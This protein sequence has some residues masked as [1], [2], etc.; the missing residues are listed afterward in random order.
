MCVAPTGQ[1][2]VQKRVGGRVENCTG[3]NENH[4]SVSCRQYDRE[5]GSGHT[6]NSTKSE[7]GSCN[8][9]TCVADGHPCIGQAIAHCGGSHRHAVRIGSAK[10][11]KRICIH[12][13]NGVGIEDADSRGIDSA[14]SEEFGR[15]DRGT[16]EDEVDAGLVNKSQDGIRHDLGSTVTA[17]EING[18]AT[19][20][21]RRR[22]RDAWRRYRRTGMR[23]AQASSRG[24]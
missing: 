20:R 21:I 16:H 5:C 2:K 10:E 11:S 15:Y 12:G 23:C 6:R 24:S 18:D 13:N 4:R 8:S 17:E 3:I 22:E 1:G 19:Q 9:G 7:G 14:C